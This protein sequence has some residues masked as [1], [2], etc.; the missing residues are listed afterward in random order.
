MGMFTQKPEENDEWAGL[1]SEPARPENAAERLTNAASVDA[2][3]LDLFFGASSVVIPVTPVVEQR[4]DVDTGEG[5]S[6]DE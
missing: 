1:P 5:S 6:P 3:G 2:G 4:E